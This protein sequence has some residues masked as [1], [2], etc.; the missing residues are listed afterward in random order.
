MEKINQDRAPGETSESDRITSTIE[1][2]ITEENKQKVIENLK[3]YHDADRGSRTSIFHENIADSG[4]TMVMTTPVYNGMKSLTEKTAETKKEYP[5][6]T[7]GW[8]QDGNYFFNQICTEADISNEVKEDFCR[9][10]PDWKTNDSAVNFNLILNSYSQAIRKFIDGN[11]TPGKRP[12]ISIGHTHPDA[13]ESYG[14]Y[15][16]PDLVN[17]SIMEEAIRGGHDDREF[18]FC[19]TVLPVNGDI[20]CMFLD[21]TDERFKKV[22]KAFAFNLDNG[23][24][25][26]VPAY[27]FESPKS[28][29]EASYV[30][31]M[32]ESNDDRLYNDCIQSI[33]QKYQWD[34]LQDGK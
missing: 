12:L 27:T 29:S 33:I 3:M 6:L 31:E 24:E 4:K 2:L 15:S 1:S 21:K 17:F 7:F 28:L 14:N 13:S 19:Q 22:T 18:E 30:K 10:H 23:D 32:N 8:V 25:E 26:I 34:T 9:Q 11:N 16:L 20:D 5:F